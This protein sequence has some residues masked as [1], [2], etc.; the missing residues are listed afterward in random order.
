M[1][2]SDN[3]PGPKDGS[4]DRH[5]PTQD[6][7]E[8]ETADTRWVELEEGDGWFQV[9]EV[10]PLKLL[11]DMRKYG[12][13]GLLS[14]GDVDVAEMLED[15]ELG[16]FIDKTVLPNVV[17]P[18]CYWSD[19]GDGDFDMA[20]LD[21]SDLLVVIV[22]MTGQDQEDLEEQMGDRFPGQSDSGSGAPDR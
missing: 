6:E 21:P 2:Q 13:D 11:R 15:G 22:G 7:Y 10:A 5:V 20:A 3:S 17:Q 19:V 14:G 12:V 9:Q 18:N 8:A 1:A 4:G 16:E